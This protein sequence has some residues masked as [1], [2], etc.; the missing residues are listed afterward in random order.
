MALQMARLSL[1]M[2]EALSGAAAL[3][4]AAAQVALRRY[5][6]AKHRPVL[7]HKKTWRLLAPLC[8][9]ATKSYKASKKLEWYSPSSTLTAN[10]VR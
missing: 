7:P 8:A 6:D 1:E 3:C 9:L 10:C 5:Q 2:V 4:N